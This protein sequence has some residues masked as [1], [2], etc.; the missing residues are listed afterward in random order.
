MPRAARNFV[1]CPQSIGK[2]DTRPDRVSRFSEMQLL[3]V[4]VI[5]LTE[6]Y[7]VVI[8]HGC[9][10]QSLPPSCISPRRDQKLLHVL[11]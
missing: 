7:G 2:R 1:C 9:L 11:T 3:A 10:R 4:N 6:K 8:T 5:K